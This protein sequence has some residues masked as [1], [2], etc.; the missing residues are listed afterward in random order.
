M[1]NKK[2]LGRGL[3]ALLAAGP[4]PGDDL[5]EVDIDR[6]TPNPG[7]PRKN[8]DDTS[9]TE[10]AKSIE[11]HGVVQP[12][13]VRAA[14]DGGFHL[15]AGER[16]W[17][18]AKKA[19]VRTVPVVIRDSD[20]K[21]DLELALIENIQ[22]EDLNPLEEAH[23]YERLMREFDLTQE[24]VASRMG[25]SRATIANVL[26]LLKLP[27]PV[28]TW[29]REGRITAGHAKALLGLSDPEGMIECARRIVQSGI[30]VRQAEA[31]VAR[32]LLE[33]DSP[34][35]EPVE[36]PNVSDAIRRLESSIGT[37]VSIQASG[38]RGKIELHFFS[39]SEMHRL[40]EGLMRARF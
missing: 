30:S 19:G 37:K 24:E 2:A 40:Y 5:R 4:Q 18:A 28:Q 6:I 29:V 20:E 11:V 13:L 7:Q 39:K 12:L 32:R 22:R 36:D 34:T 15:I 26:R 38:D 31:L 33:K 10:L 27:T 23:A 21:K 16:R 17:R 8:F 1:V 35:E 14:Q 25:K 3:S 9:I